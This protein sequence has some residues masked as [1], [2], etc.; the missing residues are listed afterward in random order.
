MSSLEENLVSCML[1]RALDS[2]A[3]APVL[4]SRMFGLSGA[5]LL[6]L[7]GPRSSE[8]LER[9][10]RWESNARTYPRRLPIAIARASG[11]FIEDVDGNVFIDFLTGAGV[12]ALGHGHP[13]VVQAVAR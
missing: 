10:A 2:E 6:D 5:M 4:D 12:L 7:P 13:E 3:A 9:Q 1:S 8:L 11:S